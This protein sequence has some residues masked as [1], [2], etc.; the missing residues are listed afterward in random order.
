M[1]IIINLIFSIIGIGTPIILAI[2]ADIK[3]HKTLKGRVGSI[4]QTLIS[5]EQHISDLDGDIKTLINKK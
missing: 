1:S 2:I 4:E 3:T 5:Q